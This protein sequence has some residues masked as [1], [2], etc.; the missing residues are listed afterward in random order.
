MSVRRLLFIFSH[1]KRHW[2]HRLGSASAA[3]VHRGPTASPNSPHAERLIGTSGWPPSDRP[4]D[5]LQSGSDLGRPAQFRG[6][7]KK[8][9]V[10]LWDRPG[11]Q[12]TAIGG[13]QMAHR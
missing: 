10:K 1:R 13:R 9:W 8:V 5:T 2:F 7:A 11:I 3:G 4:A 12:R 6:I